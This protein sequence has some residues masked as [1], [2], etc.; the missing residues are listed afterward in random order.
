MGQTSVYNLSGGNGAV[1]LNNGTTPSGD[2]YA[3]QFLEDST[4][5][6]TGSNIIDTA[7]LP[8]PALGV[9]FG[10]GDVIYGR[11]TTVTTS[12]KSLVYRT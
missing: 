10:K 6:F 9:T 2:Y 1:F 5:T 11:F 4:V 8:N 3:V 12:A 7:L